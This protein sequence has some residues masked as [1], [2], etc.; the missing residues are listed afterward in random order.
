MCFLN[1]GD[2]TS[3]NIKR[4]TFSLSQSN[5]IKSIFFTRHDILENCAFLER[6]ATSEV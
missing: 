3:Q 4:L 5:E 2:E 1:D 6:I